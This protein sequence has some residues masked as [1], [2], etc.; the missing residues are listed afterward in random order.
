MSKNRN[1]AKLNKAEDGRSYHIL[2]IKSE[3]PP[4]YDECWNL[5]PR[6]RSGFKNPKKQIFAFQVRK[7]KTWK[8]N[9]KTRWKE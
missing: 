2:W 9:R 3:F 4:Y 6:Y 8:Y 5:Y 1:R 7:Y